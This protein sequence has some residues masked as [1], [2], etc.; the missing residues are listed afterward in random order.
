MRFLLMPLALLAMACEPQPLPPQG[1]FAGGDTAA[2]A[3]TGDGGASADAVGDGLVAA[4]GSD[5]AVDSSADADAF[6]DAG[7]DTADVT[8]IQ[9]DVPVDALSD[10]SADSSLDTAADTLADALVD[11]SGDSTANPEVDATLDADAETADLASDATPG[12]GAE[13]AVC[14]GQDD[15]CDGQT[16]EGC[17]CGNAAYLAPDCT[18]CAEGYEAVPSAAGQACAAD[19]PA[20]GPR[21]DSPPSGWFVD[22]G[23]GTV[24]DTQSKLLWQKGF[25]PAGQTWD[26]AQKYCFGLTLGGFKDWRM[27]T[28]AELVTLRDLSKA[29]P[30]IAG[31]FSGTPS[32][33]FWT[34]MPLQLAPEEAWSVFFSAGMTITAAKTSPFHVRC[35]R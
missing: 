29:A 35:V 30:A 1:Y 28:V 5:A 25:S 14:N 20:W 32:E 18:A 13:A 7:V 16:D 26:A 15:D 12:C 24:R 4:D 3:D 17:A 34:A 27:P 31:A 8:D 33:F 2:W 10:A 23:D 9:G 21:P 6:A 19:F 11:A 22:Q